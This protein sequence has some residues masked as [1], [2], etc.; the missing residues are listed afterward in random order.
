MGAQ[1]KLCSARSVRVL[2]TLQ[3]VV[4]V[5]LAQS[6]APLGGGVA[7]ATT[8]PPN[9]DFA[10]AQVITGASGSV[11]GTT[12]GATH[13]AGEPGGSFATSAWYAFTPS[14]T[15][16]LTLTA[17]VAAHLVN[18]EVFTGSSVGTL[19]RLASGNTGV[20]GVPAVCRLNVQPGTT[21]RIRVSAPSGASTAG[22]FELG[23]NLGSAFGAISGRVTS[24]TTG[25][26]LTGLQVQARNV[27]SSSPIWNATTDADGRYTIEGMPLGSYNVLFCGDEDYLGGSYPTADW[28]TNGT[29]VA[30]TWE[31]TTTGVD[32]ALHDA[33]HIEGR[34]S[35]ADSGAAITGGSVTLYAADA[36]DGWL[37]CGDVSLDASGAYDIGAL[38][39]GTYRIGYQDHSGAHASTY[40]AGASKVESATDIAV[41]EGDRVVCDQSLALAAH[42]SG[43]VSDAHTGDPCPD[44]RVHALKREESGAWREVGLVYPEA[45]GAYSMGQ[46]W[47]GTYRLRFEDTNGVHA[48]QYSGGAT[49]LESAS[50]IVVGSAETATGIDA[51]LLDG[52]HVSGHISDPY[53]HAGVPAWVTAYVSDGQGGWRRE[54]EIGSGSDGTY[55]LGALAGST[56]RLEFTDESGSHVSK[57]VDDVNVAAESSRTLDVTLMPQHLPTPTTW[58]LSGKS[59]VRVKATYKLSGKITP[60]AAGGTV[61]VSFQRYVSKKWKTYSTVKKTI[62][63]GGFSATYTP[64][65]RGSWKVVVTYSG[66][67]PSGFHYLASSASRAFKVK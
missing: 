14:A 23:W 29:P 62:S 15:G 4:A 12:V 39:P 20:A 38:C 28:T 27:G 57:T 55:S 51:H 21:Y 46:L 64:R 66:Q 56:Y 61:S 67:S 50:D 33:G 32:A 40:Y 9:D 60:P 58:S 10:N 13:E 11:A 18:V 49:S 45:N 8:A 59:S 53:S 41:A 34:V 6:L 44:V 2:R 1:V 48:Y 47:P 36:I 3:I 63:A 42:I 5:V 54:A 25:Q 35:A 26:P 16:G 17:S 52:S 31:H 30:V 19:T 65:Y 37:E 22:P 24:K 43:A 7:L